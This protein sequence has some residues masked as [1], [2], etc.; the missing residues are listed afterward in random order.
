MSLPSFYDII[1]NKLRKY[2]TKIQQLRNIFNYSLY[3]VFNSLTF[4]NNIEKDIEKLSIYYNDD[5][6]TFKIYNGIEWEDV[7]GQELLIKMSDLINTFY[8]QKYECILISKMNNCDIIL[9]NQYMNSLQTHY[10]LVKY[11]NLEPYVKLKSDYDILSNSGII[12]EFP[13][14]IESFSLR[15]KYKIVFDEINYDS[16]FLY[17]MKKYDLKIIK[18]TENNC[19]MNHD[20]LDSK[21]T[22][23]LYED[24]HFQQIYDNLYQTGA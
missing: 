7:N 18:T 12:T 5:T 8:F 15:D 11:L 16:I 20:I 21:L 22:T 10:K 4:I 23:L 3:E 17:S 13:N 14:S 24:C 2:I 6:Q 19:R 9:Y 1:K